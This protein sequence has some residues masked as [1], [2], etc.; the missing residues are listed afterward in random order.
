[1][2]VTSAHEFGA[3]AGPLQALDCFGADEV[4]GVVEVGR[5]ALWCVDAD[6]SHQVTTPVVGQTYL[7]LEP[8]E[9]IWSAARIEVLLATAQVLMCHAFDRST[10]WPAAVTPS[11]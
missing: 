8:L 4:Y 9:Q 5:S 2:A 6:C 7:G 10:R 3:R 1:M 11:G